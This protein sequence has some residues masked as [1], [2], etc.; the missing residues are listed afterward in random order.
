MSGQVLKDI[1]K[2]IRPVILN[3]L[4]LTFGFATMSM[5][6]DLQNTI[7]G[8]LGVREGIFEWSILAFTVGLFAAFFIGHSEFFEHHL[9]KGVAVATAFAAVPQ[10]LIPFV[11]NIHIIIVFRFIQ[12]FVVAMVPLFSAQLGRILSD[13]RP[14]AVGI[15][16][17][18]IFLGGI[19]GS[20]AAGPLNNLFGWKA[21][22][23]LT[24]LLLIGMLIIWWLLTTEPEIEEGDHDV[25]SVWDMKFTWIWGFTFFPTIWVV[26]TIQGFLPSTGFEI[27]LEDAF[28]KNLHIILNACKVFWSIAIG[29]IAYKIST[30]KKTDRGIFDSY[31]HIM[32]ASFII[33][34]AGLMLMV[35]AL[36]NEINALFPFALFLTAG[37]QGVGPV[38]WSSPSLIYPDN[39]VS[40]GGFALGL[41][42]NSANVA[43]PIV[44]NVLRSQALIYGWIAMGVVS[45]FG[46]V[47]AKLGMMQ[48]LPKKR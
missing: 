1:R 33:A 9:K 43:A 23:I 38:F 36:N 19:F 26:F 15:V 10:I 48:E 40:R 34:F 21:T 25:D 5:Y 11:G 35:Y 20:F 41:L 44:T 47:I 14:L 17:S 18:G 24:G 31:V 4:M 37:I 13:E 2:K 6:P 3:L 32:Y 42:G 16:L 30:R 39:L 12:G 8:S 45:L 27:G 28:I 46:L 7:R 22:F 29:Y